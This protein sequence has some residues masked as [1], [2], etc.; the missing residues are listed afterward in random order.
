MKHSSLAMRPHLLGVMLALALVVTVGA[1]APAATADV[2]CRQTKAV[3]YTTDTMNLA[4]ALGAN[5]SDCADYYVSISP[6]TAAPN[7]GMP[8]GRPALAVVQ[9]QGDQF[10]ALAELQPKLVS[11]TAASIGWHA[12]GVMLHDA[13]L[14]AGY[15][16]ER[17]DTW[18]VNEVGSPSDSTVNTD[19]FNGVAGARQNFR[20]FVRGLYTGS[21]GP[22]L[23]GMVFAADA[24]Q[25]APDVADYAQKLAS[26]YADTP[27]W[28]EM[29]R[30]V[31][32][33]AQETYADA[34]AWGVAGSPLPERTAY[35]NDY[36]LHGLR[37]AADG[38]DATAAAR[39]FFA[40]AYIPLAN[41]SYRRGAPNPVTGI[42][43]GFTDIGPTGMQRFISAQTYAMRSSM[44]TRLGFAVAPIN[45]AP[46]RAAIQG[47]IAAAIRDSQAEPIGAC[48]A[49]G[50]SCDF[51]V[52]GAALTETWR[53]LANT[54]EG[55][56][57]Q[58]QLGM[59][60]A[61]RFDEVGARGASWFSSSATAD[62]PAGWAAEGRTYEIATTAIT[63]GQVRV[64]LGAEAGHVFQRSDAGWLDITSSPGCGTTDELGTVGLF[65]D[66]T[67]PVLVPHVQGQL[68]DGGWYT[69]DVTVSWEVDDPQ[70]PISERSGCET[71][72]VT[73]DTAGTTFTCV[74]ASEGGTS[75]DAV[76]VKR[77]A[78]S[79]SLTCVPTPSK[80]WPPNGKLIPVY[81]D[82]E[83][84][85]TT[86]GASGFLLTDAPTSDAV[87]FTVGTADI[88]GLLRAKRAG[89][90]DDRTY[91]L[92]YT[93]RDVAGN[94][95]QC[96]ALVVVP[97]D[98]GSKEAVGGGGFAASTS[99][100][101]LS[102]WVLAGATPP[103]KPPLKWYGDLRIKGESELPHAI[104]TALQPLHGPHRDRVRA[105][106][107]ACRK[108]TRIRREDDCD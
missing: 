63:T 27:F 90:G 99:G 62:S 89:N 40:G 79:P 9:A 80:L 75:T 21:G 55:E 2:D 4:R 29:Q 82:V 17:G 32:V 33:W 12:T 104:S 28:E 77:D 31:S 38:D 93:G 58:V 42:G 102:S 49:P 72:T 92:T 48:T 16:P 39:T 3:F 100:T 13:M 45:D 78:T 1:G 41:G 25:L 47:R 52:A 35:L 7:A 84:I 57:V 105:R 61:V 87:D 53:A 46:D 95:A 70:T 101:Y 19:V 6:V 22:V 20:D 10:H 34:R 18:I 106:R 88:A 98:Q 107:Q 68:G 30:Y 94:I 85:D 73:A 11:A 44:G 103:E 37:V 5:K 65:F 26:W 86:S 56:N 74:A 81:V 15:K 64:C 97:H 43:F 8:R 67:P 108:G 91:R 69:G 83:L 76:T 24:A 60:V 51:D 50:E 66:P 36:F 96:A 59:H 71:V 23:P 14:A 54:Q